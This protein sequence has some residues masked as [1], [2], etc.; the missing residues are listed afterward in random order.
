MGS[1][2]AILH[3]AVRGGELVRFVCLVYRVFLV[4]LV[5]RTRATR[6]TLTP[7]RLPLAGRVLPS[8]FREKVR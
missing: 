2:L 5:R 6:Q 7:D 1:G 8:Q 4:Y 3:F